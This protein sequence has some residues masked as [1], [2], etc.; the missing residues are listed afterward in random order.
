[1]N[2]DHVDILRKWARENYGERLKFVQ[3]TNHKS[4]I[5][6]NSDKNVKIVNDVE[7]CTIGRIMRKD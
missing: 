7:E 4:I 1:M 6:M 5:P 3:D 2:K